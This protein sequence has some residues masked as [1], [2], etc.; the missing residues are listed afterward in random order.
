[1]R[2]WKKAKLR[3]RRKS[4]NAYVESDK[5]DYDERLETAICYRCSGENGDI[6]LIPYKASYGI[7]KNYLHCPQCHAV[8]PTN[9]IKHK[10]IEGPLGSIQGI[11]KSSY[12]V[13]P[14]G[15]RRRV[16]RG[17]NPDVFDYT[18]YPLTPDGKEDTDLKWMAESGII[19]SIEDSNMDEPEDYN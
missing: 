1:M 17:N 6:S 8:I 12:E 16:D 18:Q 9:L 5:E 15:R 10:T 13:G 19:V 7:D 11:S 4:P 2:N 3:I 14:N